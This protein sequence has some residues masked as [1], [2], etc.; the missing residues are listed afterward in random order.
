MGILS[1]ILHS[2]LTSSCAGR[3]RWAVPAGWC[4]R[5]HHRRRNVLELVPLAAPAV[6]HGADM[7]VRSSLGMPLLDDR[8]G[9]VAR[10]AAQHFRPSAAAVGLATR[11]Q[12][13]LGAGFFRVA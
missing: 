4:G 2:R 12:C 7:A 1:G 11:S 13:A 6:W 9:W 8:C 5:R 10:L 3:V